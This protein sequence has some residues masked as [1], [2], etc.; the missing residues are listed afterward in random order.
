MSGLPLRRIPRYAMDG[1]QGE[2][3]LLSLGIYL[4]STEW[5]R[6][7]WFLHEAETSGRGQLR[8]I[9]SSRKDN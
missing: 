1:E 2:S 5:D 9:S 3:R 7:G 4:V 8:P 6:Y